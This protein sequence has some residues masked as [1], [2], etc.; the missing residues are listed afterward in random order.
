MD[1]NELP[2]VIDQ[3]QQA[4]N[5]RLEEQKKVDELKKEEDS[6]AML[7]LTALR[8]SET[9]AIGGTTHLA[10]RVVSNEP[11]VEDWDALH[12]HIINTGHWDLMQKRV[13]SAAVKLRW[14]E[15]EEVPGVGAFPV[16]KLSLTKL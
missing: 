4:R 12:Q 8:D 15:G 14:D 16:E 10:K 11:T 6:L 13:G 5:H 7:I 9:E 1:L 2:A 3:Y